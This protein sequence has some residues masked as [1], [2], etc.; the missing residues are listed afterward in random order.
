[1]GFFNPY[2]DPFKYFISK[3]IPDFDGEAFMKYKNH[4]FVYTF[5]NYLKLNFI[6]YI[7]SIILFVKHNNSKKCLIIIFNAKVRVL[8]N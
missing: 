7:S 2:V 5:I 8:K 3:N 1:M 6:K 4:N